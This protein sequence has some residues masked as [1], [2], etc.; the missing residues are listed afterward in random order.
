MSVKGTSVTTVTKIF[1]EYLEMN[2]LVFI[3][4]SLLGHFSYLQ[5][6]FFGTPK[7]SEELFHYYK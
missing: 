1:P 6:Y 4:R 2:Q 5:S 3:I 7:F